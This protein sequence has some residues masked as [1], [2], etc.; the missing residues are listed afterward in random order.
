M[1][2]RVLVLSSVILFPRRIPIRFLCSAPGWCLIASISAII[3]SLR[4]TVSWNFFSKGIAPRYFKSGSSTQW[5]EIEWSEMK[6]LID[7][8]TCD[9]INR[10]IQFSKMR[11]WTLN[12]R[13]NKQIS[14]WP[15]NFITFNLWFSFSS[16]QHHCISI[17]SNSIKEERREKPDDVKCLWSWS[18][19]TLNWLFGTDSNK[20]SHQVW[21][22]WGVWGLEILL[23]VERNDSCCSI[24]MKFGIK[25][26]NRNLCLKIEELK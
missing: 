12:E 13:N 1:W 18:C 10:R 11:N 3:L 20:V 14:F 7:Y 4:N 17:K 22:C 21:C 8:L 24:L 16:V 6:V 15:T 9:P 25:S 19:R 26:K 5:N 23:Q 2:V